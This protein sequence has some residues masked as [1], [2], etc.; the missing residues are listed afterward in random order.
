VAALGSARADQAADAAAIEA[1]DARWVATVATKDASAT[2]AFYA[3]DG[4][5]MPT[6]APVAADIFNTDLPPAPPPSGSD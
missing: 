4:M 5:I 2:A 1:L 3:E 6:G